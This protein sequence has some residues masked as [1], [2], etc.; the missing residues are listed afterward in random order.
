MSRRPKFGLVALA[1][2]AVVAIVLQVQGFGATQEKKPIFYSVIHGDPAD[3]FWAVYRQGLRDAAAQFPVVVKELSPPKFSVEV[4]VDL[5]NSAIAAKP[6]GIIATITDAKAVEPPLR[7]AIR[8]GI[9]VIAVNVD[10]PRPANQRIPYLFY[11]G[12]NEELGGRATAQRMLRE[13]KPKRAVCANHLPGHVGLEARCRGFTA[14]MKAAGVPTDK[15]PIDLDPTKAVAQLRGYFR[16]HPDTD[17][18]FTI[19]PPGATPALQALDEAGLT[20]KVMHSSFDMS[21][22]QIN[23]IKSGKI[24]STIDQ[25]QYLQSYLGVEFL[26]LHVK[27]GFTPATD[28]LTGPFVVDKSNVA[29][30]EAGVKAG[31][32]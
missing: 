3:T 27:K 7:R 15:I 32:R 28:I 4:L 12:G 6:D 17:A 10:D 11:I 1:L 18:L 22:E 31:Y 2:L 21:Q 24:L 30:V 19:G 9:P 26:L 13:R 8:Q 23:A 25:Q 16:S 14:V 29:K 5:L 20:G